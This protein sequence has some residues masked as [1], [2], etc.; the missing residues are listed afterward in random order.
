MFFLSSIFLYSILFLIFFFPIIKEFINFFKWRCCYAC[1][2][3]KCNVIKMCVYIWTCIIYMI[4]L[5]PKCFIGFNVFTLYQKLVY[6]SGAG[7]LCNFSILYP[8][9]R[10]C[11]KGSNKVVFLYSFIKYQLF[12]LYL[13]Y[14]YFELQF[15][16]FSN[17][18]V[19]L[20]LW[21]ILC[22]VFIFLR[23][24]IKLWQIV[25]EKR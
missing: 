20:K 21:Y 25:A 11:L 6:S 7:A 14:E 15:L 23:R 22:I 12:V 10:K 5:L 9:Y 19:L 13:S 1:N 17:S 18:Y 24:T 3:Q 8:L 16:S 4:I 2:S